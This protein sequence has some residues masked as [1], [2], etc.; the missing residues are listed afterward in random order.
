MT[1]ESEIYPNFK[2]KN[3]LLPNFSDLFEILNHFKERFNDY[4]KIL[5]IIAK[6]QFAGR[7]VYGKLIERQLY[8]LKRSDSSKKKEDDTGYIRTK[9]RD[10]ERVGFLKQY[11]SCPNCEF[12]YKNRG[13][14]DTCENCG[15]NLMTPSGNFDKKS[16]RPRFF[17]KLT[18]LGK[19]TI[20]TSFKKTTNVGLICQTFLNNQNVKTRK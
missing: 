14:P 19:D 16:E 3:F 20:H 10:L 15:Y 9:I 5:F 4:E 6:E 2:A 12:S 11:N 18:E 8:F 1:S 13:I 17:I 7:T